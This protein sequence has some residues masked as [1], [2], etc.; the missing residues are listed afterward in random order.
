[1]VGAR[2]IDDDAASPEIPPGLAIAGAQNLDSDLHAGQ[3]HPEPTGEFASSEIIGLPKVRDRPRL[4]GQPDAVD[5][6]IGCERIGNGD[7]SL[8]TALG[9]LADHAVDQRHARRQRRFSDAQPDQSIGDVGWQ[10]SF[11]GSVFLGRVDRPPSCRSAPAIKNLSLDPW[12]AQ[13]PSPR[14]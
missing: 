13:R 14:N 9:V 5:A 11:P 6:E 3:T 2:A 8:H 1:M 4:V 12:R 7:S 10:R